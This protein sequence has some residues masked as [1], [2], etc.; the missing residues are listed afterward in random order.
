VS[1]DHAPG[2]REHAA[3]PEKE[4][5]MKITARSMSTLAACALATAVTGGA[6]GGSKAARDASGDVASGDVASGDVA[7]ADAQGGGAGGGNG[8]A[9]AAGGGGA[10]GGPADAGACRTQ[11]LSCSSAQPC[12]LPLICAGACSMGVSD[13]RLKRD[14]AAVDGERILQALAQLPITTWTYTTE[15]SGVRH[16]GP[17]AQDFRATFEVGSDERLIMQVDADGVAL[18]AIKALDARVERLTRDNAALRAD[19][20]RLRARERKGR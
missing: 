19:V 15:P 4:T 20:A 1:R 2:S 13:R 10:G 8:G 5:T 12:C 17:M 7:S 3:F 16:I 18:A 11:G 9:A 14:F 6:C